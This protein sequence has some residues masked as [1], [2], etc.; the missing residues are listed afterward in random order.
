VH[1][2]HYHDG[3]RHCEEVDLARAAEQFGTPVYTYSG[4]MILDH[5]R[6]LDAALGPLDHLI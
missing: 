1:S 2:F 5:Y 3:K 6:R 4:G